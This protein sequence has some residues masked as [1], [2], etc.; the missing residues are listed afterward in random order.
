MKHIC[1]AC[2]KEF[3]SPHSTRKYCSR[4]CYFT[5]RTGKNNPL[6]GGGKK[7]YIHGYVWCYT[8]IGHPRRKSNQVNKYRIQ[9][10][11]L[12]M[13]KHLGR[14]LESHELVHHLN[15]IKDDNR[16]DNLVVI[17]RAG[18]NVEHFKDRPNL[19][20]K[21]RPR[22]PGTFKRNFKTGRYE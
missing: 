19:Y 8:P 21:G 4:S 17:S 11:R 13:E 20:A 10:H 9:E 7:R 15:G 6:W 22:K 2:Q 16:I 3:K 18:H 12:V 14:Y 1:Q 5:T